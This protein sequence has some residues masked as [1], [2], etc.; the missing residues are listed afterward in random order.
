MISLGF[1][2]DNPF[3][4]NLIYQYPNVKLKIGVKIENKN[5]LD[6]LAMI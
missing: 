5:P 1:P 4:S 6:N 3:L 2:Y